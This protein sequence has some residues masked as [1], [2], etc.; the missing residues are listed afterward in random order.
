MQK[1]E[2]GT[3][4]MSYYDHDSIIEIL[5]A[6]E[7]LENA[8]ELANDEQMLSKYP[9]EDLVKMSEIL[10]ELGNRQIDTTRNNWKGIVG[11]IMLMML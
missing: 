10:N 3:I 1:I 5:E 9:K 2:I 8:N 7:R 11:Y 4:H 6:V